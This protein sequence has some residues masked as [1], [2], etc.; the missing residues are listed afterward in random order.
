MPVFSFT[1]DGVPVAEIVKAADAVGVAIRGGDLAALPLL[2]R[3]GVTEAARASAYLYN[4]TDE[5]DRLVSVLKA[6]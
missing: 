6:L 5:I 3:F 1:I 4:T 2:Q